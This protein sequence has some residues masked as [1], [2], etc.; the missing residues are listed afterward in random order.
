ML[1]G[2]RSFGPAAASVQV[3]KDAWLPVGELG[4]DGECRNAATTACYFVISTR[5]DTRTRGG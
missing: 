5:T 3:L 1:R 4:E 2:G